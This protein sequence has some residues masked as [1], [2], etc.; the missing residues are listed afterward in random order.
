MDQVQHFAREQGYAAAEYI[1]DW[2]G[3]RA[4]EPFFEG[5]GTA[6]VGLPLVILEKDGLIRMST[7]EE[8]FAVTDVL[9]KEM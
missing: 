6:F 5:E 1:C 7:P 9:D 8:A 4:Y 3:W 2:N